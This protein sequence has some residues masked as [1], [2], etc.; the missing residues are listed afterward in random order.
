MDCSDHEVNIKILLNH[1]TAKKQLGFEERKQLLARMT[2][3]VSELVLRNNYAQNQALSLMQAMTVHRLGSQGH[4][5][6][7]LE[8][9]NVLDREL[10]HLPGTEELAERRALGVGL[11]RPELATCC[12]TAR[13]PCIRNYSLRML[14]K[15]RTCLRNWSVIFHSHCSN[16]LPRDA[17]APAASGNHRDRR[18]QQYG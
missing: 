10:E 17:A 4:F 15:I 8:S 3:E 18:Y 13:S 7:V 6:R 11:T 12:P 5:I 1:A 9:R 16:T 14:P 2:D